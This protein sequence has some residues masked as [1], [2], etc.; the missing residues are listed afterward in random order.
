[1][2]RLQRQRPLEKYQ[3]SLSGTFGCRCVVGAAVITVEA[4]AGVVHMQFNLGV[5]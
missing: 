4:V 5:R 1:L 3:R 2:N